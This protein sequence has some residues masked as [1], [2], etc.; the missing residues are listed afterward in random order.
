[1][2]IPSSVNDMMIVPH[3]TQGERLFAIS[4]EQGIALA[5]GT[6]SER[7]VETPADGRDAAG[8][9]KMRGKRSRGQTSVQ[10]AV[11]AME[12][13]GGWSRCQTGS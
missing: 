7:A 5:G 11:R 2:G 3:S 13:P 9:V 6:G 1:M 10:I 8:A 12:A 4:T